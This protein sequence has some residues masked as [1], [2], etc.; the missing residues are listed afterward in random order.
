MT[1]IF[2]TIRAKVILLGIIPRSGLSANSTRN[3]Q[4]KIDLPYVR[5]S[6]C[7]SSINKLLLYGICC[8]FNYKK[9]LSFKSFKHQYFHIL[10]LIYCN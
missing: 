7:K 8:Q 10:L 5:T 2:H 9:L 6:L 3:S 1:M 4:Y